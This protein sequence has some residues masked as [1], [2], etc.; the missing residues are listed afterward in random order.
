[1][2]LTKDQIKQLHQLN[3]KYDLVSKFLNGSE[4]ENDPFAGLYNEVNDVSELY[5]K[6]TFERN[7]KRLQAF[8]QKPKFRNLG[9]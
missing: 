7:N 4:I 3:H 5:R 6:Q 1:M 2:A 9:G 8:E